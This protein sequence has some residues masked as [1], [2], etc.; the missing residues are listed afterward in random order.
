[1]L[2][3]PSGCRVGQETL[4]GEKP[5][6]ASDGGSWLNPRSSEGIPDGVPSPE[7]EAGRRGDR[8]NSTR[9]AALETTYGTVGGNKAPKGKPHER[10]RD[11]ISPAGRGGSKASGG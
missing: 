7:G 8:A 6:G 2:G 5:K 1:V 4:E 10:D 9:V 3:R 11:E